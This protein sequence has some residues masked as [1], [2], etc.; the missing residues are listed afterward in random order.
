MI[1]DNLLE[2]VLL[3]LAEIKQELLEAK[4]TISY[5]KDE[6]KRL[7]EIINKDSSNSSKPPS[8]NNGFKDSKKSSSSSKTKKHRG[9]QKGSTSNNL[10]KVS[11][12]D[13]I[14]KLEINNC[15]NC[16]HS[17]LEVNSKVT[18]TKQLFDIPKIQLEVTEYQQ[19]TK[20]CPCCNTINKPNYP[21]N[22]KSYVQYGDNIKTF[23]SY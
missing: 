10:K 1:Q 19:H 5:L 3:E 9:G 4:D 17:L 8:T 12:P 13:H 18:G 16:N 22:L 20:T 23:I 14:Q 2:K 6:N 11:K 21:A 7:N 15:K